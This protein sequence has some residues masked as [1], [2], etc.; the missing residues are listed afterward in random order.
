MAATVVTSNV[1]NAW[2][3]SLCHFFFN[4]SAS[5][6]GTPSPRFANSLNMCR[7]LGRMTANETYGKVFL[8][9]TFT[10]FFIIPGIATV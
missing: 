9:Y 10:M 4:V 8:I 3:V 2:Q 5:S 6:C 1:V 7:F